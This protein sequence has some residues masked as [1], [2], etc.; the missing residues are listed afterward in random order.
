MHLVSQ[1]EQRLRLSG[2]SIQL[3]AG[4]SI[5]S[6]CSYKFTIPG[7]ADL[8][9]EAGFELESVWTDERDH[10]AVLLLRTR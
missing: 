2:E 5:R 8:A 1:L 7:F 4:E 10:F 6:E 9:E 3:R